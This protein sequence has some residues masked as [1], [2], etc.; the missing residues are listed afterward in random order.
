MSFESRV[1]AF[2]DRF[3][4]SRSVE[5]I[6]AP[7]LADLQFDRGAGRLR[8]AAN[9]LAVIRAVAGGLRDEAARG[10]GFFVALTLMTAC[11]NIVLLTIFAD[12][13]S[14]SDHLFI[15]A[16]GV[17]FLSL[18]PVMACFWPERRRVPPVG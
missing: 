18:G 9:H 8:Q 14:L 12:F 11:Y 15:V 16:I 10:S 6:V 1:I 17:L 4:S 2:A 7:A 3:L 5:L 13:V